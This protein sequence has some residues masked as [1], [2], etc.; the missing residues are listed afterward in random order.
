M[1]NPIR[2]RFQRTA[3]TIKEHIKTDIVE[4][5][6]HV[7]ESVEHAEESVVSKVETKVHTYWS[8]A[9]DAYYAA[10]TTFQ[11]A[12]YANHVLTLFH[13]FHLTVVQFASYLILFLSSII[14]LKLLMQPQLLLLILMNTTSILMLFLLKKKSD[15]DD[16]PDLTFN[17]VLELTDYKKAK[18]AL[19][20]CLN[21]HNKRI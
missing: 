11:V 13:N 21:A 9:Q 20:N 6:E 10:K 8:R 7:I 18:M 19:T 17:D 3:S 14:S 5:V 2:N 4:P 12:Y 16:D 1:S 15:K